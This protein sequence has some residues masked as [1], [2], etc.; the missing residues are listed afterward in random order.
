M[1]I[2]EKII[3]YRILNNKY[4]REFINK[5]LEKYDIISEEE[6]EYVTIIKIGYLVDSND[7]F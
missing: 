2:G 6:D 4:G 7:E 5:L 1:I 3:T